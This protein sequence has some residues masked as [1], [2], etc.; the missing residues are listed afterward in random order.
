MEVRYRESFLRDLKKLKKHPMYGRVFTL[1]FE[2]LP[3]AADL[4]EVPGVRP[5][6]GHPDR[7]RIR[8]GSYRLG[9]EAKGPHIELVRVL[10]R[11]DFY[12]YFP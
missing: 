1:A 9:I 2:T 7:Y 3:A 10:D 12:R 8:T 5:M 6:T 4:R 11:R